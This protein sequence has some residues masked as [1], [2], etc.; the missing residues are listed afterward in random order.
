MSQVSVDVLPV[1]FVAS[2]KSLC[3]ELEVSAEHCHRTGQ[4][5]V[6]SDD[7]ALPLALDLVRRMPRL[8]VRADPGAW[9]HGHATADQPLAEVD[10]LFGIAGWY[11]Q[12]FPVGGPV[13][14]YT[15]SKFLRAS[16][17]PARQALLEQTAG[18]PP[19]II[20]RLA[21][22]AAVL[23]AARRDDF[24]DDLSVHQGRKFSFIFADKKDPI[25]EYQRIEGLR[26]VLGEH[27]GSEVD[28]VDPLIA[29]DAL[30][31]GASWAGVGA[32]SARRMPSRPGD[33]GGGRNS[34][35]YLPGL[36]L[37]ELLEVRSPMIYADWYANSRS[38]HCVTC[39]RPLDVF[40]TT[41]ADKA[42][43]IG[44]NLHQTTAHIARLVAHAP[45]ARAAYLREVR[46]EAH[47]RHMQLNP[48]GDM[49]LNRGLHK[50]LELDDPQM[51]SMS[52]AGAWK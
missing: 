52:R 43:I 27:P 50:F 34:V 2:E 26:Q 16:D 37:E 15:P 22:E 30:A 20:T 19:N 14:G 23:E 11:E 47:T 32:S 28:H 21:I 4:T 36:F 29:A 44:H 31:S 48:L 1:G 39:A 3:N 24:L 9:R 25:A 49:V 10:N 7:R 41:P 38:P 33:K 8:R 5:L 51:R 6:V 18:L 13:D 42:V 35:G 46:L 12:N 17:R 45:E 40:D